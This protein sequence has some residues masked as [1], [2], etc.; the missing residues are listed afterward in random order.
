MKDK[1]FYGA[2][3]L[4][5]VMMA[6]CNLQYYGISQYQK[7]FMQRVE[8]SYSK[9]AGGNVVS[10]TLENQRSVE[11]QYFLKLHEQ[12]GNEA[13]DDRELDYYIHLR[14]F[15]RMPDDK[16]KFI[17]PSDNVIESGNVKIPFS[18]PGV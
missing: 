13:M 7:E 2:I 1:I 4:T 6:C 9:C 5:V 16:V 8:E 3:V 12:Y 11:Y 17:F 18:L 10:L 15:Y 14:N